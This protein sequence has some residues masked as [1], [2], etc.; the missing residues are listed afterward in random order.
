MCNLPN[1]LTLLRIALI[2]LLVVVYYLPL[3]GAHLAAGLLFLLAAATDWFDGYLARRLGQETSFGAFFDPVADK[4]LVAVA[5]L[6][7]VES[8][9]S[10]WVAAPA[11]VIIC[12]EILISALREWMAELGRRTS[13]AVSRIAKV[14]TTFQM[15]AIAMLLM[16]EPGVAAGPSRFLGAAGLTLLYLAAGLTLW[17]ASVYLKVAWPDLV[18]RPP[19][20]GL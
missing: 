13:V 17:T 6:V 7:V 8:R 15:A 4:L 19:P 11:M 12:R 2:P 9:P 1:R 14:K 3:P 18:R 10:L 16:A 5:L 20:G